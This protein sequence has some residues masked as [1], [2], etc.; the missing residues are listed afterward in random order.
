MANL[1]FRTDLMLGNTGE[2]QVVT[3]LESK[4]CTFKSFNNDNKYDL[5]M[6]K[7]GKDVTYE[8]KTDVKCAP[9]F[10]TGNIFIEFE[11]RKKPSGISTTQAEWFVTYFEYLNELWFIK[12]NVLKTLIQNNDFPIFRDA[13]DIGSETH[14]YL[15]KRKQYLDN[16][17][18]C[19]IKKT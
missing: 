17:H 11:S 1:D 2:K 13:G 8:I 9:L 15:I 3:F 7:N 19:K 10:D 4:G 14:G 5:L 16:F 18:V 6:V 12:T